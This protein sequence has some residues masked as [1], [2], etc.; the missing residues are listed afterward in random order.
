MCIRSANVN[1]LATP[2]WAEGW[3]SASGGSCELLR[4]PVPQS[5]PQGWGQ[6]R[7]IARPVDSASVLF[8]FIW[9]QNQSFG[10]LISTWLRLLRSNSHLSLFLSAS[11]RFMVYLS[12]RHRHSLWDCDSIRSNGVCLEQKYWFLG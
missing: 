6:G 12:I 5:K 9:I 2:T 4:E 7:F 8:G 3:R 10:L 1:I 11:C